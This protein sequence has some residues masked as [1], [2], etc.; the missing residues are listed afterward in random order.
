MTH[1]QPDQSDP[2]EVYARWLDVWT[3]IAFA[4]AAVALARYAAGM[5]RL[6]STWSDP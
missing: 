5:S 2:Q 6:A 1:P 4:F 3:H